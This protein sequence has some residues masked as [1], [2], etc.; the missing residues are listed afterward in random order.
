MEWPPK[1]LIMVLLCTKIGED[2]EDDPELNEMMRKTVTTAL[3]IESDHEWNSLN[4]Q[5]EDALQDVIFVSAYDTGKYF[6]TYQYRRPMR[7]M[8]KNLL[9]I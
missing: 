5:P 1:I 8:P 6:I 3:N 4:P 9:S 7:I 2:N